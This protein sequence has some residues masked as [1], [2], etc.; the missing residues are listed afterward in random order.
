MFKRKTLFILGAGASKEADLPV[1]P[2]L[3]KTISRMLDVEPKSRENEPGETLLGQLYDKFPLSNSGYHLAAKRISEGVRFANSIDDFLD[4]HND[5]EALQRVG[6]AAIIKSI[7]D[8]ERQSLLA[9][10]HR[11]AS[12]LN[13]LERTWYMKFFR[14][15]G[16]GVNRANVRQMFDNVAFVVFNYDRCLE[17]FLFNVLSLTYGIEENEAASILDDLNIVHPYGVAGPLLSR[18][19]PIPFGG[20]KGYFCDYAGLSTGVKIFTEQIA[21]G[22]LLNRVRDMMV[23]AEQIVFLGFGYHEPNLQLLA[24]TSKMNLKPVIGT[25]VGMSA[26]SIDKVREQ[27]AGMFSGSTRGS[28]PAMQVTDDT[29]AKLLD[30]HVKTLPR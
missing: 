20:M 9:K 11:S 3:A 17:H 25:A 18:V 22:D 23:W 2:E 14:M 30:Y 8:A 1:G 7:L 28:K 12:M 6:K 21:A 27:L 5:D 19:S 4:R 16:D 13:D 10:D 29:C 26:S 15:L 24:P